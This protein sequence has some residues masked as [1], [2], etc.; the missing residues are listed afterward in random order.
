MRVVDTDIYIW[1]RAS[2]E[3]VETFTGHSAS[4]NCVAWNPVT[5]PMFASASDD[6]T[7]RMYVLVRPPF[8]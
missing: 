2:G 6:S 7:I 3:L 8:V 1:N 5:Q 4:V